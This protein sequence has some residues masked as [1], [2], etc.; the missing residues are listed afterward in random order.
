MNEIRHV[1]QNPIPPPQ[2]PLSYVKL[3]FRFICAA[4]CAFNIYPALSG[5]SIAKILY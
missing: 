2:T 1:Y 3:H 4:R 5:L